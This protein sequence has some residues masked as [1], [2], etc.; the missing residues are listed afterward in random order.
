[1]GGVT[2]HE[3]CGGP[4]GVPALPVIVHDPQVESLGSEGAGGD[5]PVTPGLVSGLVWFV[6]DNGPSIVYLREGKK[7]DIGDEGI[8]DEGEMVNSS[9][10]SIDKVERGDGVEVLTSRF[11]AGEEEEGLF[12][13]DGRNGRTSLTDLKD[14]FVVGID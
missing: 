5:T 8:E 11:E 3:L 10:T 2:E 6:E 1:M 9:L 12:P 14:D 13:G 7:V 4:G